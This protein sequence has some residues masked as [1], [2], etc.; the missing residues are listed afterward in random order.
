MHLKKYIT[1]SYKDFLIFK[2]FSAS[3]IFIVVV[4]MVITVTL[5][6]DWFDQSCTSPDLLLEWILYLKT[7]PVNNLSD[8]I[9]RYLA[10]CYRVCVLQTEILDEKE[11]KRWLD[12]TGTRERERGETN[13]KKGISLLAVFFFLSRFYSFS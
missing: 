11:P 2:N 8:I 7:K 5:F 4:V 3:I 9:P 10:F 12:I 1:Y 13:K 6:M